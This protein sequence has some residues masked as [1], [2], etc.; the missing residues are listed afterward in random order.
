MKDTMT[1]EELR[2]LWTELG[3]VQT[4]FSEAAQREFPGVRRLS[5]PAISRQLTTDPNALVPEDI[6]KW[7]RT[8]TPL[9]GAASTAGSNTANGASSEGLQRTNKGSMYPSPSLFQSWQRAC[10]SATAAPGATH[11]VAEADD[12]PMS[13]T[14]AVPPLE[15]ATPTALA[16]QLAPD[17][18]AE[19]AKRTVTEILAQLPTPADSSE[20]SKTAATE[21]VAQQ[22]KPPDPSDV[23]KQVAD[24]LRPHFAFMAVL[25]LTGL[26]GLAIHG[27]PATEVP[28]T[29]TAPV[30]VNVGVGTPGGTLNAQGLTSRPDT[31]PFIF[32]ALP[33]Q[34]RGMGEKAP[35]DRSIPKTPLPGQKLAPNCD[36]EVESTINGAC[37]GEMAKRPPCGRKLFRNGDK[38]YMPVAADPKAPLSSEPE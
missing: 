22:N 14:E 21:A 17:Q 3:Y 4:S 13:W 23:A 15:A 18:V 8:L 24:T 1:W 5:Q 20:V 28:S 33:P 35:E 29:P 11:P 27:R 36:S 32:G 19:V 6:A 37:W 31:Q 16:V 25:L 34:A 9:P 12:E 7:A 26:V 30:V 2:Q 38:C 10:Q